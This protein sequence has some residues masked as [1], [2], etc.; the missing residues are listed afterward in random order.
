[1]HACELSQQLSLK[2]RFQSEFTTVPHQFRHWINIKKIFEQRTRRRIQKGQGSSPKERITAIQQ[3][4][5]H[6]SLEEQGQA[7]FGLDD[8]VNIARIAIELMRRDRA[9]LRVSFRLPVLLSND[10]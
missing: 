7:H 5:Q 2:Y 10:L 1:M 8:S 4:L 9:E 6:Y 3:M